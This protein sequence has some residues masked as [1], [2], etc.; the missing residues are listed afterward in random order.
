MSAFDKVSVALKEFEL[1]LVAKAYSGP[2]MGAELKACGKFLFAQA[3]LGQ[4]MSAGADL[5]EKCNLLPNAV[6]LE[7]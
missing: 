6:S 2:D 5:E 4:Q 3:R 1:A 7:S